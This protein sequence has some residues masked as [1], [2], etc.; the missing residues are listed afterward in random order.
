VSVQ[1]CT[2]HTCNE[3]FSYHV[4]LVL[5]YSRL[6]YLVLQYVSRSAVWGAF[7]YYSI[8]R[9]REGNR[10]G[11]F[12]GVGAQ[13]IQQHTIPTVFAT[14]LPLWAK[15]TGYCRNV[16]RIVSSRAVTCKQQRTSIYL[17]YMRTVPQAW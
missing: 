14:A 13:E 2:V 9:R 12:I 16:A 6:L 5:Q 4:D 7:R 15:T 1:T 17:W 10:R 11:L 3:M 8:G